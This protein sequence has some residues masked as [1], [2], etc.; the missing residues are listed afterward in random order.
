MDE[1]GT[2]LPPRAIAVARKWLRL[3]KEA[4]QQVDGL[5]DTLIRTS[6]ADLPAV[7]DERVEAAY[8]RPGRKNKTPG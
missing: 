1:I 4:Q 7:A 5:L 8:G 2:P 3:D 6:A